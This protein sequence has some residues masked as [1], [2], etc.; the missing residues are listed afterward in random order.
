M[1]YGAYGFTAKKIAELAVQQGIRPYIAGR[2]ERKT[3]QLAKEL[4]L[5]YRVFSLDDPAK[6]V[7]ALEGISVLLNAA[8]PYIET[9]QPMVEACLEARCHYLDIGAEFPVLETLLSYDEAAKQAGIVICPACGFDVVPTDCLAATLKQALPDASEFTL[10][11]SSDMGISPGSAKSGLGLFARGCIVRQGGDLRRVSRG[12]TARTLDYTGAEQTYAAVPWADLVSAWVSTGIPNIQVLLVLRM[13]RVEILLEP[14][15]RRLLAFDGVRGLLT[16]LI[17]SKMTP[18]SDEELASTPVTL[19]G[20]VRN[21]GGDVVRATMS[22][23]NG[24]QF[25][26]DAALL[27]ARALLNPDDHQLCSPAGYMSPS[28]LLGANVASDKL[29]CSPI[30]LYDK[31]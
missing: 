2:N 1:I 29:G 20:E 27:F 6:V 12:S 31:N 9:A 14:I 13:G 7:A 23:P 19:W 21:A 16:R 24:Y 15:V 18:P 3:T 11:L 28:Q 10:S 22:G 8:G 5:P 25:T 30:A 4:G 26:I 17:N